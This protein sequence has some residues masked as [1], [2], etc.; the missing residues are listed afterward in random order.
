MP[1]DEKNIKE[2]LIILSPLGPFYLLGKVAEAFSRSSES[3]EK[4]EHRQTQ[5]ITAKAI[6]LAEEENVDKAVVYIEEAARELACPVCRGILV[7]VIEYLLRYD[8]Y[9]RLVEKGMTPEQAKE[10]Y[11]KYEPVVKARVGEIA[12]M[13]RVSGEGDKEFSEILMKSL[14]G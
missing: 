7:N 8:Y 14:T 4:P 5:E 6:R 10:E 2:A 13:L 3:M 11:K 9:T 1:E 12:R